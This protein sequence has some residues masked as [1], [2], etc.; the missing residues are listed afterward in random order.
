MQDL[1][2]LWITADVVLLP[3]R[4]GRR[5]KARPPRP[6]D[7]RPLPA[8]PTPEVHAFLVMPSMRALFTLVAAVLFGAAVAAT[9][10]SIPAPGR[11]GEISSEEYIEQWKGVAMQKMKD[12]GIPASITLAQGLLESRSGNSELAR[13]ANNHFGIK[14]T[15]DWDGG[16]TYHDDDRRHE[17]FRKYSN[18]AQSFE[19]HSRFLQRP[20]YAA[21]FELRATDYKGW[22]H[23][24]KKA[25]YA[26]DPR[27]PTKLIDLIERYQLHKLDEGVD[28]LYV[29]PM[30][31]NPTRPPG[32]VPANDNEDI[33]VGGRLIELF[34]DRIKFI[35]AKEGD[36]YRALADELEMMPGQL[37]RYNDQ[38][39]DAPIAAGQ[40][41]YMQPK[42]SKSK[43]AQVHVAKE[44][45]T[46]WSISQQHG[47]KLEKLVEYNGLEKDAAL[48]AGRQVLLKKPKR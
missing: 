47:V 31:G 24:L 15:N 29:P 26:T 21:L 11:G 28:V 9:Q 41:V 42:R 8:S 44:G 45:E 48:S 17:C 12:H 20:R 40:V 19:D 23:G 10:A 16:K 34:E 35:R 7:R 30:P 2:E 46:L 22:A 5:R 27:Y 38:D 25:G 36:T 14:C 33:V 1:V 18:A 3:V 6:K 32:A 39:P 37:A 13:E 43:S 4:K